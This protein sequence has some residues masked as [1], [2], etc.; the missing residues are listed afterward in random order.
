MPTDEDGGSDDADRTAASH[1]MASSEAGHGMAGARLKYFADATGAWLNVVIRLAF[2]VALGIVIFAPQ[3]MPILKRFMVKSSEINI[4]GSK[5]EIVDVALTGDAIKLTD[6]GK[7]LIAGMDPN[8]IPDRIARLEQAGRDLKAENDKLKSSAQSA[9]EQLQ[10][11]I[12]K[13]N[14]QAVPASDLIAQIQKAIDA[15][16][17]LTDS[18]PAVGEQATIVLKEPDLAPAVGFGIVFGGDKTPDAAMDEVRKAKQISGNP[19]ILFKRQAFWRSVM[20]F[21][22]RAAANDELPALQKKWADAYIVDISKWCPQ[23]Q[24]VSPETPTMAQQKDCG[25]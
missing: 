4:L 24:R 11:L 15:V 18:S 1:D 12:K 10:D 13:A 25:F 23:P 14:Q 17:Q 21:G 8:E 16:R 3:W 22:T 2:A 5:I 7:I 6:D 20:F 19:I 9:A